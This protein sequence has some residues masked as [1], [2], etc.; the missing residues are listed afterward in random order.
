MCSHVQYKIIKSHAI[1]T[2]WFQTHPSPNTA[3]LLGVVWRLG[4]SNKRRH[5]HIHY[6]HIT[7]EYP[8]LIC[9]ITWSDKQKHPLSTKILYMHAQSML[10]KRYLRNQL[11]NNTQACIP[12]RYWRLCVPVPSSSVYS[13][14]LLTSSIQVWLFIDIDQCYTLFLCENH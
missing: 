10:L 4:N 3:T 11:E 5:T 12:R 14:L 6:T 13:V 9:K 8:S 1:L 2:Y 7:I